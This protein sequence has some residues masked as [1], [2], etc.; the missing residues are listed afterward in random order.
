MKLFYSI[1]ISLLSVAGYSQTILHQNE[2]T[3][4]TVQDPQTVIMAPGF[5]ATSGISNPFVA[6]IGPGTENPGGGPNDSGAGAGNPSGTITPPNKSFHDTKGNIEVDGGGQL[7]FTLPIALPPGIKS[8]APQINLVYNSGSGNG[9]A[10]YGWNLSG[11]TAISRAGKNIE[12]DGEVK[13]IQIDYSDYYTF[14]GQRLI[15]K[16]GEYGKDGAEY[17]TEKYS[18]VKIKSVGNL[19]NWKQPEYW[20]VTFEDGSQAW[21][22]GVTSGLNN[23]TNRLNFNIVKWKDVQ[24][25][26]INYTYERENNV[27]LIKSIT[28]GGNEILGKASFNEIVFNYIDRNLIETTYINGPGTMFMQSKLL[29]DILVTTNGNQFKKYSV[30]YISDNTGYQYAK[31]ITESNSQNEA[32]NPIVFNYPPQ[33]STVVH[34]WNINSQALLDKIKFTGDFNGDSYLDF[35]MNDGSIKLGAFNDDFN[36]VQTNKIFNSNSIV[37]NTLLDE[38]GQV[39]NGNGIAEYNNSTVS[40]YVFRNNSFVKV[41]EKYIDN[42]WCPSCDVSIN[43][44]DIDGDGISDLFII[45]LDGA[46]YDFATRYLVDLKNS[47]NPLAM[48]LLDGGIN[49]NL[50][51]NQKYVDVDGDGK[52]DII[53]VSGTSYT[54]FEF[55]KYNTNQYLKKIKFSSNL[56][57]T[58]G[59]GFPV[60]FGDFNGDG[61]LDFTLPITEGKIGKDDWRFYIGTGKSFNSF[62]K[63]DFMVYRNESTQNNN[64]AWLKFARTMYSISDLNADG[65]SDIVQVYSYSNLL[66]SSSRTIGVTVNSIISKGANWS[67]VS[68]DFELQNIYSFPSSGQFTIVQPYDDLS[69]YQPITNSI[70]S[71]NNYYNVFL[72]R[73]DNVLKIKAPTGVDEL[74][75]VE[76]I[77]QG[78]VTT[79]AKYLEV[80]PDNTANPYFYK[81]TRDELYPYF[82][83]GRLDKGYA[84]SQ[85]LQEGR[86]QDFRYRGM[87]VH[88]QGKGMI[89]Y[90]QTAR[91]TWYANGFENTKIWSGV[92]INPLNEG[93]PIKEWSIRTN[94][95]NK[96]FPTDISENNTQLLSFKSTTYQ[97]DKLLNG[98]LV[99]TIADADKPKVVTAIVPKNSKTKDFLTGTLNASNITYGD[100]YLP[101]QTTSNVNNGYA[102]STSTV[103]YTHNLSGVGVDYFVGRPKSKTD[104]SQAYS[105]TKSSKEEYTY[106]NNQLKTLKSWNR[107]STGYLLETYNYDDFGNLT[108]K[109][110]GNSIDSQTQTVKTNYDDK[111]RFVIK[112]TDNLGLETNI[113]YNNWGQI[114]TQTDPLGNTLTNTYDAWGK[115][116]TSKTNLEGTTTYQY[117]RDDNSNITVTQYDPDGNISKK[118]INKL[119]QDYKASTKAFGQGQFVSKTTVYDTL[120]R[121]IRDSEPYFEGQ[122]PSQW[123]VLTYDDTVF[124]PKVTSTALAKINTLDEIISFTGKKI[125]TTVSGL[126]TII[127]EDNGY[128]RTNSKTTDA[129]GNVLSSNDKGGTIQFTFN[130]AGEQVKAQYAE[131]IVTTKYDAWGRKSEFND[132]SNGTY[133]YEYDGFG[134][135]KKIISPKGTKEY[136]LNHLGQLISQKE[137]S[138]DGVTTNKQISFAYDNKGR[139]IS[140]SG[141]SKGKAYSSNVSYDPQG[142]VLSSSESSNGK[143]FIQKG[144]TYDDK[145][146]VISYE[147]QLYSSGAITKVQ[148]ENVYSTWNGELY[149]VR[150]KNSGKILWELKETNARG[151]VSKA[152]LGAADA[153]NMYDENGFLTNVNHSS[154]VK[155]DILQI[156]YSFDGIKNELRLRT[157]GGDF[158][159]NETFDYDDNNRLINWTNPVTGVKV[160]NAKLNVYDAKGRILENDQVGK[161]KFENSSKIYQP[162]GMILNAAGEQN[163]NNDLIQS[164]VYNENN[165]PIFI[166]GEKG[167]VAFQYGLTAMRQR[168]TYGGNFSSDGDG[169]FTKFYSEGGSFEVVKDNTTGKE[170]HILYIGGTPY[171]S[172]IVYLKNFDDSNGSYKFLHK[173]YIGSILAMSDEA[174]NKL[175][176]RHFDAWG[177]FTHLQIGNGAIITDKNIINNTSLLLE[178]GYTSHEHFAEVGIIHMN[179][180]LYDPLLR[181]FLN[182]DENIQDPYNT[183]NY[184]KYGYVLNNPLMFNDP[185]GEFAFAPFIALIAKA[186]FTAVAITAATYTATALIK[187]NWT[188]SGF[189]RSISSAAITG[190]VS[191]ALSFGIGTLFQIA[192][193]AKALGPVGTIIGRAGAH[194]LSMGVISSFTGGSFWSGAASGAFASLVGDLLKA[195]D[196]AMFDF[197][198]LRSDTGMLITGAVSGGIGSVLAGGNFWQGAMS[199]FFVIAYNHLE[200]MIEP[201]REILVEYWEAKYSSEKEEWLINKISEGYV[202]TNDPAAGNGYQFVNIYGADG[203]VSSIIQGNDALYRFNVATKGNYTNVYNLKIKAMSTVTL[204]QGVKYSGTV[205]GIVSKQLLLPTEGASAPGVMLG[206]GLWWTGFGIESWGNYQLGNYNK[207]WQGV[208]MKGTIKGGPKAW[209]EIQKQLK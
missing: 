109:T 143:Y 156:H 118:Y 64:G 75:R 157:T 113:T 44:G 78:D 144:I 29:K 74:K 136:T 177:N 147:K 137:L 52:I 149:Q 128:G 26:I 30:E 86:K 81:K 189:F 120:G 87:T 123:N 98:Q 21:Y 114:L 148:I 196:N 142:R 94:D 154:Q 102:I 42:F 62:L 200:H 41:F 31:K 185:S 3:T 47:N 166:D 193:V 135:P 179:G 124:P 201:P 6:K 132:P 181:R 71:N 195:P 99:S 68:I 125:V 173:D 146:R 103:E 170:K 184:N 7:Q 208:L 164:V 13:S 167:D 83:L 153:N 36:I 40:V 192:N 163:Y 141:T 122:S 190:M 97:T 100:Y 194:S 117:V 73:K 152:K 188:V 56:D 205:V 101:L 207:I 108:Q 89:G 183:Q 171:E 8:V 20:E 151:Q 127:K 37:V 110:I 91:S 60:L 90:H 104:V 206:E 121:K 46:P 17:I 51:T 70:R 106:E 85:L 134:Q 176:Q 160:Q 159:I 23:A 209:K 88:M 158:S 178:R 38:T 203:K 35:V 9:I 174:G 140:K 77:T 133:K 175:E 138:N 116:L 16:S 59:N 72:F 1:I 145:A 115:S 129:L 131:N 10:G 155:T 172:N 34:G 18:N 93:V 65:K 63:H 191:G 43:E 57:E 139:V 82:S 119:G 107:D 182:A 130:A 202:T 204:G 55:V 162:T 92:E 84:I 39:F 12:K 15:L 168:V 111:G 186:A 49:E 45:P 80:V 61:K 25:N 4:R 126:T 112:K 198:P 161:I 67:G 24:G 50:Y 2:S 14:N 105:D 79:S 76:S 180:R 33:N 187:G 5:R 95:E 169:K 54:V 19:P 53:D 66:N 197:N 22:G 28:W 96:I 11:I 27:S 58:K 32:A 150:D 165:D 199:G 69:I 48:W